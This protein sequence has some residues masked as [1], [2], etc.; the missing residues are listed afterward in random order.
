MKR[1]LSLIGAGG[2][3]LL[4]VT[5]TDAV[6]FIFATNPS[7]DSGEG[8]DSGG[9]VFG[10]PFTVGSS[11]V[12]IGS[13]GYFDFGGGGLTAAHEVGIYDLSQTLLGS[14]TVPSGASATYHDGTRWMALDTPINLAANTPYMLAF[15]LSDDDLVRI[16]DSTEVTIDSHFALGGAAFIAG[17]YEY[18]AVGLAYPETSIGGDAYLFGGNMEVVPEP[19]QLALCGLGLV[20]G[21]VIRRRRG[22][23]V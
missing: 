14:V 15:K 9:Y 22:A 1:I 11:D 10:T 18:E 7:N 16:T 17:W 21:Y 23:A 20:A 2:L 12:I 8:S 13:L 6:P 19:S 3:Y 5:S 4:A